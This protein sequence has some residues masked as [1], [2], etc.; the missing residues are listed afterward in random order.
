MTYITTDTHYY[1]KKLVVSGKR[2]ENYEHIITKNWIDKVTNRDTVIHLGDV[3]FA[4]QSQAHDLFIRPMPGFKILVKGNHDNNSDQWYLN[5]GWTSVVDR[6]NWFHMKN[7]KP[8]HI[9]FT[10]IPIEDDGSFDLNIHGH[11]HEDTHRSE[12]PEM[13]RIYCDKHR[14]IALET[15]G[16]DLFP[17]E[18]II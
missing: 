12:E 2:P 14:L 9:A 13:K 17:I 7:G 6:L 11:F 3:C 10:H 1:H 8:V 16:Y 18:A 5:H 15:M 4:K